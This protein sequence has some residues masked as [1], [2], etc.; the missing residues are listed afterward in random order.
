METKD[1]YAGKMEIRLSRWGH[2]LDKLAAKAELAGTEAKGDYHQR[3]DALKANYKV[4]QSKLVELKAAGEESG[5]IIKDGVEK[6]WNELEIAF[7]KLTN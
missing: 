2:K 3:L 7:K 1:A 5:E 4:A 6:A